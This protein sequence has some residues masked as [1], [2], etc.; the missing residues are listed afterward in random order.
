MKTY[1]DDE[2]FQCADDLW[3]SAAE[4][5]AFEEYNS[6][7]YAAKDLIPFVPE[8][9]VPEP[10][11]YYNDYTWVVK[12]FG[13][14]LLPHPDDFAKISRTLGTAARDGD[15]L[16]GAGRHIDY[17]QNLLSDWTGPNG[18]AA[19][20]FSANYLSPLPHVLSN[21]VEL[22]GTLKSAVDAEHHIWVAA[23][24]DVIS[25]GEKAMEAL[26]KTWHASARA[27][28]DQAYDKF[29]TMVEPVENLAKLVS[30][31][32]GVK[33]RAKAAVVVIDF[34]DDLAGGRD[35]IDL[36][37]GSVK[38]IMDG[39]RS[40]LAKVT[41]NIDDREQAVIRALNSIATGWEQNRTTVFGLKTPELVYLSDNEI[42]DSYPPPHQPGR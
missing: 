36:D 38:D 32:T 27:K 30:P 6:I 21:Q 14:F 39:V 8:Q 13:K 10:S 1:S 18:G 16:G 3:E 41:A 34:S 20:A 4:A 12:E 28:I 35:P 5:A 11:D 29:A 25:I 19:E 9:D 24:Q 17:L 37:K 26:E 7:G 2:V 42:E 22:V 31:S 15:G 40:G 33:D 23:R